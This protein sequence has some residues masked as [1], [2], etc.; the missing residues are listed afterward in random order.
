MPRP[1]VERIVSNTGFV[2][3]LFKSQLGA[4][5]ALRAA[6]F[7]SAAFMLLNDL[8]FLITW[9]LIMQRFGH[10]R[11]WQI[12]DVMCL[13]GV[14]A[15]GYGLCVIVFGGVYDLSRKIQD[16]ELDTFL[17]QPK[18]VLFQAL[19]SQTR[20]SGWGDVVAAVV[21]F[22]MSG[23][24]SWR[25]LPWLGIALC[26]SAVTF[27]ACGVVMHSLAFWL[28]RIHTLSRS[29]WE[30]TLSFSLYPPALFEGGLKVILFTL[31]PAGFVS[32]LPVE[33]IRHPSPLAL[34]AAVG[35]TSLY[36]VFA[37][38]LFA[39]GLRHYGSGNRFSVKV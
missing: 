10:V 5:F 8:L 19:A 35:G 36:A 12:E 33:L 37:L 24:V 38:W 1:L 26:C 23:L 9:W 29:L 22:V 2:L 28:G 25:S 3:A 39:R 17:V 4:S 32:Y 20:P 6:F 16:G 27:V 34:V 21:L 11:G 15:G 13:Y 31:L 30:F 14:S 7:T 18:N